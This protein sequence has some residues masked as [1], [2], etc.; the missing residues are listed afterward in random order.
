MRALLPVPADPIDVHDHY[1]ADWLDSGGIR[2]NFVASVDGAASTG[3]LSRG[4]QTSGD[5][6]VFAALRDLADVILVGAGT[7]RAEGYHTVTLSEA[8]KAVRRSF[9]LA[10]ALPLAVVSRSARLDPG[11][12]LFQTVDPATRTIV[13]TC[14][15]VGD[16]AQRM[17]DPVADVLLCG[18]ETV[19]L[20]SVRAALSARGL[21]RVLCEGG[22]SLFADLVRSGEVDELCLSITPLLAG[23]GPGRISAGDAWIGDPAQLALVGLLEHG[24]ALFGRY[25]FS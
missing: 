22:P 2:A 12:D 17:L 5:N 20:A 13:I 9:G 8:R 10:P 23:P 7:A 14:A 15:N 1:A 11:S 19:D 4:L 6:L 16:A 24:G 3:G 21:T 18:E 25:R